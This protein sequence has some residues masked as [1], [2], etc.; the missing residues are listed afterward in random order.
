MKQRIT[1]KFWGVRGSVPCPGASTLNYGGNTPCVSVEIG[2]DIVLVLDAGTGIR[3]LGKTLVR[4][5]AD[6]I[7]LISHYHWDHIQGLPFFLPIYEADREIFIFPALP[8]K[9]QLTSLMNQMDGIHF[10]VNV[11]DLPSNL[12]YL[13]TDKMKLLHNKGINISKIPINH[14]GGGFGYRI[15]NYDSSIVYLTDNELYPPLDKMT[16]FSDFISFC[17]HADILIHDAQYIEPDMPY[18]HGWGHSL[19]NHACDLAVSAE[20]NHLVLYHH[21]PERTDDELNSLE[22]TARNWI[23]KCNQ[24]IQCAF[25]YEGLRIDI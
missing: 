24:K 5:P 8:G 2:S 20:V 7:L 14:P 16:N 4:N 13:T 10:P 22:R 19:I 12:K 18:K 1:V 23:A 6:I 3:Q 17:K 15:D 11:H 9:E 21:D 25:A